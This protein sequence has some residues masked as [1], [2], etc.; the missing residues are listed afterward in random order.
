[1]KEI[2]QFVRGI[3]MTIVE[4]ELLL[5]FKNSALIILLMNILLNRRISADGIHEYLFQVFAGFDLRFI[6]QTAT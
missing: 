6:S 4:I 2:R 5:P 1:M 3:A